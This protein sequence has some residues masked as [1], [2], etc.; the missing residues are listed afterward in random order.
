MTF[1]IVLASY[2]LGA[3]TSVIGVVALYCSSCTASNLLKEYRYIKLSAVNMAIPGIFLIVFGAV[4]ATLPMTLSL[5]TKKATPSSINVTVQGSDQ[6]KAL[7][8]KP[9]ENKVVLLVPIDKDGKPA[10]IALSLLVDSAKSFC[11]AKQ[12]PNVTVASSAQDSCEKKEA[13]KAAKYVVEL[14]ASNGIKNCEI[15]HKTA[16]K[17]EQTGSCLCVTIQGRD[18]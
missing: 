10:P 3:I 4:I 9:F 11:T 18:K 15:D 5:L 17:V 2:I 7:P 13:D 14:L 12:S 1:D 8:K 6:C 16:I